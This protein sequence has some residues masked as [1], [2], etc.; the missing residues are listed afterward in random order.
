MCIFTKIQYFNVVYEW[1]ER[2]WNDAKMLN[3]NAE[4]LRD[5]E[6]M[7]LGRSLKRLWLNHLG[8]KQPLTELKSMNVS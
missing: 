3:E 1:Q 2:R 4:A 5:N 7:L 6:K 8:L